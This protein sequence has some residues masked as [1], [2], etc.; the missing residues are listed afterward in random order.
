MV[1]SVGL[2]HGRQC[3][4]KQRLRFRETPLPPMGLRHGDLHVRRFGMVFTIPMFLYP[5]RFAI[6]L[7]TR[8]VVS[9][10]DLYVSQ[11]PQVRCDQGMDA[12]VEPLMQR[13][14]LLGPRFSPGIT[15]EI[16]VC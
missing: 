3:R 13:E 5:Q 8:H 14:S 1:R 11:V 10:L 2:L 12:S 16:E 7:L 9:C 15:A 4:L 6:I